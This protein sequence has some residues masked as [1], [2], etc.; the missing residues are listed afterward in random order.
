MI[1]TVVLETQS[2]SEKTANKIE[3]LSISR[4]AV[5][6]ELNSMLYKI[7]TK[8]LKGSYDSRVRIVVKRDRIESK[9]DMRTNKTFGELVASEP[10]LRIELSLH[11][12]I[13]G[14]NIKGGSDD[15]VSQVKYV[16]NKL[17]ELLDVDLG[18]PDNF[19]VRRLDYARAY[20]LTKKQIKGYFQGLN[21]AEYPRRRVL[22]YD[23]TGIYFPG[24][25]TT[26][27]MYDKGSEFKKH[28]KKFLKNILDEKELHRLEKMAE[29]VLR[30][31]VEIKSK[32]LKDMYNKKLPLVKEID[33][34]KIKEQ[35]EVELMRVLKVSDKSRKLYN[36]I[37]EV[38]R[39]LENNYSD[40]HI[41][42]GTWF[43]LSTQGE[44]IVR[45]S[46]AKST[47]YRHLKKLKEVG[48][49][50]NHTNLKVVENNIVE[51]EFNPLANKHEIITN[52][53]EN[54]I[55]KAI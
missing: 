8:E 24:F 35:F 25:Y 38:Q 44:S 26:L 7:T 53:V 20:K 3:N 16:A 13:L 29:N 40:A 28:D 55:K 9:W 15:L 36:N 54:K 49:T 10:Y 4:F 46:M 11:K 37:D 5:D 18:N 14:H 50:W 52:E 45:N 30:I 51:L 17:N 39:V 22:K 33:M 48:V 1:D 31:E 21:N 19:V 6:F 43:R 41:L 47:Y 27:K 42:F 23:D 2:L 32:K 34:T 12:F